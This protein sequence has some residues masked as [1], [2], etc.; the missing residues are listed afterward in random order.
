MRNSEVSRIRVPYRF[1]VPAREPNFLWQGNEQRIREGMGWWAKRKTASDGS[2]LSVRVLQS[3][4]ARAGT[5]D[6]VEVIEESSFTTITGQTWKV[7]ENREM[8]DA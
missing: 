8:Y 6:A 1:T 3:M 2:N 4:R 7:S 5:A